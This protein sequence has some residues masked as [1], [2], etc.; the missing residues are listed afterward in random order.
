MKLF[1]FHNVFKMCVIVAGSLHTHDMHTHTH[2]HMYPEV[3]SDSRIK[4]Y[5]V[6]GFIFLCRCLVTTFYKAI[7]ASVGF[8]NFCA[9]CL[10]LYAI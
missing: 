7:V 1:I 2:T 5:V 3:T 9:V 8:Y 10:G 6:N 4:S